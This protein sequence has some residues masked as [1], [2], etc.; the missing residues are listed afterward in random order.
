[1]NNLSPRELSVY[2]YML[3]NMSIRQIAFELDL[4]DSTVKFHKTNIYRKIKNAPRLPTKVKGVVYKKRQV[5]KYYMN[6]K[7][8]YFN[9]KYLK[10]DQVIKLV[11]NGM[12]LINND[13]KEII[14]LE[15]LYTKKNQS[16]IERNKSL[17][18]KQDQ[19][20]Q[21]GPC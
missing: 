11:E 21:S 15:D 19:A 3:Q 18:S 9:L 2:K 20:V 5:I 7:K 13:T 10:I 14:T 4:C 17:G 12:K 1:M 8:Y 6:N 16:K